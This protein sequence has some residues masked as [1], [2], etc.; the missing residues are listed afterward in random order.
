MRKKQVSSKE[1]KICPLT[2]AKYA[3]TVIIM[4]FKPNLR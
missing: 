4:S 2:E 1:E 3:I